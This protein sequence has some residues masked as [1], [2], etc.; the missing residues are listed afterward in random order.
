MASITRP[1]VS[2][3]LKEAAELKIEELERSKAAFQARY[4]GNEA[5]DAA[6]QDPLKRAIALLEQIKVLDPYLEDDD[7]LKRITRF[8]DQAKDDRSM[9][10]KISKIEKQLMEKLK[11]QGNRLNVSSLHSNV[12]RQAMYAD[13]SSDTVTSKLENATLEDEF[14]LVEEALEGVLEKFEKDTF[15]VKD[16]DTED[17][18]KFLNGLFQH[19]SAKL[20]LARLKEDIEDYGNDVF[21]GAIE[22]DNEGLEWCIED[23]LGDKLLS[24]ETRKT[25]EGYLHSPAAM[26]ELRSTMNMKSVRHWNWRNVEKGLPVTARQDQEGKYCITV[27]EDIIDMIFLHSLATGW[28]MKLKECLVELIGDRNIWSRNQ[29]SRYNTPPIIISGISLSDDRYKDY[30]REFFLS[31]LPKLEG[32]APHVA[33]LRATKAELM[34]HL[35]QELRTREVLQGSVNAVVTDVNDLAASLPHKTILTILKFIGVP[36]GWLDVFTRFLQAPLNM[37]PLVRG[38]SDRVRNRAAGL[39]SDHAMTTLLSELVMFFL[40]LDI[41]KQTENYLYRLGEKGYLVGSSEDCN[42]VKESLASFNTLMGTEISSKDGLSDEPIGFV[43]FE[44]SPV[45]F[46]IN[47]AK[48]EAFAHKVKKELASSKTILEWISTWNSAVGNYANNRFGPLCNVFG[49]A[50]VEAVTAAHNR[51]HEIIFDGGNLTVHFKLFFASLIHPE[52]AAIIADP[53]FAWEP[54]MYLPTAYGGL[55]IKNP[56]VRLGLASDMVEDPTAELKQ[57]LENEKEYYKRASDNFA[58]MNAEARERK[59]T[60]LFGDDKERQAKTFKDGE[61]HSFMTFEEM[62]KFRESCNYPMLP[63]PPYPQPIPAFMPVPNITVPCSELLVEVFDPIDASDRVQDSVRGLA[64][65]NGMKTWWRT[66]N[67]QQWVLQMYEEECFEAFGGLEIWHGESV[68]LET[69]RTMRG[70]EEEDD[71]SSSSYISR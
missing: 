4:N 60:S 27:D 31:E 65:R 35:A 50:H 44:T 38:T 20:S 58:A 64:G 19:E 23:L 68:P 63:Y 10:S 37:G 41:H 17:L 71:D 7:D 42:K 32:S 56:Y 26:R 1:Y 14:E 61:I 2:S 57:Y 21:T 28:S 3:V 29:K 55:G 18:E 67:E 52:A 62:I 66:S 30:V 24:D 36:Q 8:I 51:I 34:K 48:V 39:P 45:K 22:V 12:L 15:T 9:S 46:T 5:I 69:L 53:A 70:E 33:P 49:K 6:G 43:N 47:D 13:V 25:L 40:D 11:L 16:V 54:F 59:L